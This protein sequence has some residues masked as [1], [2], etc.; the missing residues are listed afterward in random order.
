V[1]ES[2]P[3]DPREAALELQTLLLDAAGV[4]DF[5]AEVARRAARAVDAAQSCGVTVQI[6]A[7]S[8]MLGATTDEFAQRMDEAQ[9]AVDDGPCLTCL[10]QGVPVDVGDIRADE[11]W[12]AFARRGAQ[13]GAGSSLSV[14]MVVRARTV[15]T[16]NLY[17]RD[18]HAMTGPD[19]ARAAEFAGH[20]AGAVALAAQLAEH[21]QRE[22]RLEA[23]LRSRSTIDQAM[24]V[25]MAQAR[26]TADEA[27]EVLRRR[28]QNANVKLRDVAAAVIAEA[29]RRG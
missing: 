11:R 14:P 23:A 18:A 8:R 25:L 2:G 1:Q 9:Y 6:S 4:E 5:L 10:R 27:F 15:G 26:I 16:L 17:S 24:G 7:T 13:E 19:R 28:S 29:T 20:A 12:P 22:H 3:R 21:A